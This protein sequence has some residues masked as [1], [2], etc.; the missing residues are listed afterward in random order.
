MD[1]LFLKSSWWDIAAHAHV[2]TLFSH[3]GKGWT[4]CVE[5]WYVVRGPLAKHFTKADVMYVRTYLG[6]AARVHVRI[7]F[8]YLKNGWTDCAE[9]WCV[10][11]GPLAM[12]CTQDGRFCTNASVPNYHTF[13]HIYSLPLVRRPKGVILVDIFVI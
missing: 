11:R 6:T 10:A 13:K 5:I 1:G 12:R 9:T 3:L 8:P 7:L 4:D 2:R